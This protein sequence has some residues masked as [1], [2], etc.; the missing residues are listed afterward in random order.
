MKWEWNVECQQKKG[1]GDVKARVNNCLEMCCLNG[2][3]R[4]ELTASQFMDL[5]YL[6]CKIQ[7]EWLFLDSQYQIA[8]CIILKKDK[9]Q[10]KCMMKVV[11]LKE[12]NKSL[13]GM[14]CGR[15][16]IDIFNADE[17]AL[18]YSL[19]QD[20]TL[21]LKSETCAGGCKAKERLTILPC[22]ADVTEKLKLSVIGKFEKPRC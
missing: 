11:V 14:N 3:K 9:L 16:P 8:G 20:K 4:R 5:L 15:E 6:M 18:F 19:M 22:I 13:P 12:I 7:R 1:G 10:K 17:S 2:Y 21:T